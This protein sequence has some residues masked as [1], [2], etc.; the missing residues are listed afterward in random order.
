MRKTLP[1]PAE[2]NGVSTRSPLDV[3]RG[4]LARGWSPIPIPCKSKAP[5]AKGWGHS[6][7]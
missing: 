2:S 5:R 7:P 3:A 4:Y 6:A 1:M